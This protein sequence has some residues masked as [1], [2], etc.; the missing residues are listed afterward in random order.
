MPH[1]NHSTARQSGQHGATAPDPGY[2]ELGD[3]VLIHGSGWRSAVIRWGQRLWF[4]GSDRA[5]ADWDHVAMF[6]DRYGGIVE[7]LWS[8]VTYRH[9]SHYP[10][11][12]Y[13]IVRISA[14]ARER[15]EAVRFAHDCIDQPYGRALILSIVVSSIVR[16]RRVR[17]H[18]G[19]Q[20]C[21]SLIA[22]AWRQTYGR[23]R[24]PA[25]IM[26]ADLARYYQ[27]PPA[28]PCALRLHRART[29]SGLLVAA[30]ALLSP[31]TNRGAGQGARTLPVRQAARSHARADAC[32]GVAHDAPERRMLA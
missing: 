31:L 2:P 9:I 25:H 19:Q 7:A 6:V 11:T 21:S 22:C 27:V 15:D 24:P 17:P 20:T 1:S 10:P 16:R 23:E 14:S 18:W 3:I 32:R 8:G 26:P 28:R 5:Y 29:W 13:R 12:A 30:E 4:R